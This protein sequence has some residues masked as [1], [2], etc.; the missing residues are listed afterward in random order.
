MTEVVS[1]AW[2]GTDGE[3]FDPSGFSGVWEFFEK[4]VPTLAALGRLCRWVK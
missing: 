1:F 3:F 4:K 2:T